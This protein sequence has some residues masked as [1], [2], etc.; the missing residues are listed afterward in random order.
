MKKIARPILVF[1]LFS[2][3]ISAVAQQSQR[4]IRI[5][6]QEDSGAP[7]AAASVTVKRGA[8][9]AGTLKTS[10]KGEAVVANLPA[11]KYEITITKEGFDPRSQRDVNLSDDASV[12]IKF[13]LM[14]KIALNEKIEVSARANA[15]ALPEQT[16][17]TA[18]ELQAAEVKYLPNNPTQVS[19][20]LP[21][22]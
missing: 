14:P 18:T 5:L 12:E 2:L 4:T 6:A 15:A 10:E 1:A 22:V 7:I 20:A 19:D 9:T 21:L 11:G 3:T 13:T 8:E 16:A 17:S